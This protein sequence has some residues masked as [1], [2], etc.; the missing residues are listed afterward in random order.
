MLQDLSP[1]RKLLNALL[2]EVN[3]LSKNLNETTSSFVDNLRS[4]FEQLV[5]N[6]LKN[7]EFRSNYLK[8]ILSIAQKLDIISGKISNLSCSSAR[9]FMAEEDDSS[10]HSAVEEQKSILDQM[11]MYEQEVDELK[12]EAKSLANDGHLQMPTIVYEKLN[13]IQETIRHNI[14]EELDRRSSLLEIKQLNDFKEN[15]IQQMDQNLK[16]L[17]T[18]IFKKANVKINEDSFTSFFDCTLNDEA[19][20]ENYDEEKIDYFLKKIAKCKDII[21]RNSLIFEEMSK[22]ITQ[23]DSRD[24]RLEN[25]RF[26]IK[27]YDY[28]IDQIVDLYEKSLAKQDYLEQRLKNLKNDLTSILKNFDLYTENERG[29]CEPELV[30][31][32]LNIQHE[33]ILADIEK[34]KSLK[35]DVNKLK[36]DQKNESANNRNFVVDKHLPVFLLDFV[37]LVE[38]EDSIKQNKL[39]MKINEYLNDLNMV[40]DNYRNKL[41]KILLKLNNQV[42]TK[43]QKKLDH[44]TNTLNI[45]MDTLKGLSNEKENSMDLMNE[46]YDDLRKESDNILLERMSL[47]D[48]QSTPNQ[49]RKDLIVLQ[50]TTCRKIVRTIESVIKDDHRY[51]VYRV[52]PVNG[53][54]DDDQFDENTID[55]ILQSEEKIHNQSVIQYDESIVID[56]DF[57]NNLKFEK[58][59]L[60]LERAE[61]EKTIYQRQLYDQEMEERENLIRIERERLEMEKSQLEKSKIELETKERIESE[62]NEKLRIE[63]EKLEREKQEIEKQEREKIREINSMIRLERENL[64]RDKMLLEQSKMEKFE[65]ERAER[66]RLERESQ[67]VKRMI[68]LEREKLEAEKKELEKKR[69]EKEKE[70][71]ELEILRQQRMEINRAVELERSRIENERLELEKKEIM[72]KKERERIEA[73]RKALERLAVEN[74][75]LEIE[76]RKHEIEALEQQRVELERLASL[77]RQR[78]ERERLEKERLEQEKLDLERKKAEAE[79]LEKERA[80][81]ERRA[82][83]ERERLEKERLDFEKEKLEIERRRLE[84]EKLEKERFELEQIYQLEQERLNKEKAELERQRHEKELLEKEKFELEKQRL[85]RQKLESQRKQLEIEYKGEKERIEQERLCLEN[86][87]KERLELKRQE[88]ERVKLIENERQERLK[89]ERLK[90]EKI[91]AERQ[92]REFMERERHSKE[93]AEAERIL[94]LKLKEKEE[95]DLAVKLEQ[96]RRAEIDRIE[97][98]IRREKLEKL[99]Q[100]RLR[101]Q[102]KFKLE[103]KLKEICERLNSLKAKILDLKIN[104]NSVEQIEQ[105]EIELNR[106]DDQVLDLYNKSISLENRILNDSCNNEYYLFDSLDNAALTQFELL[107]SFLSYL[108]SQIDHKK[109][110]ILRQTDLKIRLKNLYE[111]LDRYIQLADKINCDN[112]GRLCIDNQLDL[113]QRIQ[114][115]ETI[116]TSIDECFKQIADLS[117]DLKDNEFNRDLTTNR[118]NIDQNTIQPLLMSLS[119]LKHFLNQWKL[120]DERFESFCD[121]LYQCCNFE[122]L[123]EMMKRDSILC[124]VNFECC[125]L[126]TDLEHFLSTRTLMIKKLAESDELLLLGTNLFDF[127]QNPPVV[128]SAASKKFFQVKQLIGDVSKFLDEKCSILRYAIKENKKFESIRSEFNQIKCQIEDLMTSEH[129]SDINNYKQKYEIIIEIKKKLRELIDQK[130]REDNFECLDTSYSESRIHSLKKKINPSLKLELEN[131]VH[132]LMDAIQFLEVLFY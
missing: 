16:N 121:Y 109:N 104:N 98:S 24:D 71:K 128:C 30:F 14:S 42:I 97:N 2:Y 13:C 95:A 57:E 108:K 132:Y 49:S 3:S 130:D 127:N 114:S 126:E 15:K 105:F 1:N 64:E 124:E 129:S 40:E 36:I 39:D 55:C 92:Q 75:K 9:R 38:S 89:Q 50:E 61:F 58:D 69:I 33:N 122:K 10:L 60:E 82:R 8:A 119:K 67:E 79:L 116:E 101:N 78:I 113:E 5:D 112:K 20:N 65:A 27:R 110:Q 103:L 53:V 118:A 7:I 81:L 37:N 19:L 23:D 100:E 62:R 83:V 102:Q 120:F 6:N 68:K 59:R 96:E 125:D 106:L 77:E 48:S 21:S 28:Q 115:M 31:D 44:L 93:Q 111:N 85:E 90:I 74:E 54:E 76:Q 46:D 66:E 80:E 72:E 91:R 35:I 32:S 29:N 52:L 12:L 73:E 18:I 34:I 123:I 41:N 94:K 86:L 87:E 131:T 47:D 63:R 43:K 4:K 117:K 51:E 56:H 84:K 45:Q 26:S 17:E 70:Q 99:E 88:I 11:R 107:R 22:P 25:I